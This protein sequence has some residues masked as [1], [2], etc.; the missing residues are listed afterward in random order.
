[1]QHH[2]GLPIARE[3]PGWVGPFVGDHVAVF[4]EFVSAMSAKPLYQ[5][6]VFD[7]HSRLH[8]SVCSLLCYVAKKRNTEKRPKHQGDEDSC[9][10]ESLFSC[11]CFERRTAAQ[12]KSGQSFY[13]HSPST[14]THHYVLPCNHCNNGLSSPLVEAHDC[15]N[16]RMF[17]RAAGVCFFRTTIV[18]FF[19]HHSSLQL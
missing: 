5:Q 10:H 1:M 12:T 14:T 19:N 18:F 3:T 15:G 7:R 8:K 13:V 11:A 17:W 2:R 9:A 4:A 16:D 6:H